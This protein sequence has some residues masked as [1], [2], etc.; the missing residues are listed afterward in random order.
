MHLIYTLTD[1]LNI[2]KVAKKGVV[3]EAGLPAMNCYLKKARATN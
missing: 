3:R 1:D 2:N